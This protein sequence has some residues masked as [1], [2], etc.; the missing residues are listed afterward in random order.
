[1]VLFEALE[2]AASPLPNDRLPASV[3]RAFSLWRDMPEKPENPQDK[4]LTAAERRELDRK[5]RAA[6]KLRENLMR[7]K[8][9]ARARRAGEAD[10]TQGLPAA[11]TDESS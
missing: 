10:E 6:A 1:M 4:S 9:Q 8:G 5:A 7:R 2:I 11:K 3:S